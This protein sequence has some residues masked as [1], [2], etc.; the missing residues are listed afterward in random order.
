MSSFF[1]SENSSLSYL[2][3]LLMNH[4]EEDLTHYSTKMTK[5]QQER[6]EKC[7]D[8][9]VEYLCNTFRR[10]IVNK[11][12]VKENMEELGVTIH[13]HEKD[14]DDEIS[15]FLN[16]FE[17][18]EKLFDKITLNTLMSSDTFYNKLNDQL[19]EVFSITGSFVQNKLYDP[20]HKVKI[21]KPEK[22]FKVYPK[23]K[24][25]SNKIFVCAMVSLQ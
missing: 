20:E 21:I 16:G 6:L 8:E 18:N 19:N 14:G 1:S 7:M 17:Q 2:Y 4:V 23:I 3:N 11:R 5:E 12:A 15:F 25:S 9:Y 13:R 22:V 10:M 24:F